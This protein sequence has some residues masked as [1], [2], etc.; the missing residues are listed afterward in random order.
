MTE[1]KAAKLVKTLFGIRIT[2]W[3]IAVIS[4]LYWIHYQQ[5]LYNKEIFDAYEY[6]ELLR[7]VLYTCLGISLAAVCIS[8]V[9]RA[10][11]DQVKKKNHLRSI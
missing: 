2:L 3:V 9:L 4:T 11:S 10:I 1:E 6:S 8:F 7:P 5:E